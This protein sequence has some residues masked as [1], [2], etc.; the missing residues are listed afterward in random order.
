MVEGDLEEV[1][2][3][4]VLNLIIIIEKRLLTV[5]TIKE[6]VIYHNLRKFLK[7][8]K[9]SFITIINIATIMLEII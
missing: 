3:E 8:L 1:D 5:I 7:V 2:L 4:E 6:E 9:Q